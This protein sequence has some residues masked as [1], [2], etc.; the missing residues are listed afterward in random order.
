MNTPL[1]N[2]IQEL[3]KTIMMLPNVSTY[4]K[5]IAM[6]HA[7]K[8]LASWIYKSTM[9]IEATEGDGWDMPECCPGDDMA[10]GFNYCR[11]TIKENAIKAGIISDN[12]K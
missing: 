1:D 11:D 8:V 4:E 2:K 9:P 5:G 6:K 7:M 12:Q 10:S 3:M